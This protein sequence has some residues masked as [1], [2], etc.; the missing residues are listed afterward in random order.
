MLNVSSAI[1]HDCAEDKGLVYQFQS[2]RAQTRFDWIE[3]E[4]FN[5]TSC[6]LH[7][8]S[9]KRLQDN[10]LS[11]LFKLSF[12]K[13]GLANVHDP[14]LIGLFLL[15][16]TMFHPNLWK[17]SSTITEHIRL[18]YSTMQITPV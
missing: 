2:V 6:K 18:Q 17:F 16:T 10:C 9:R 11:P 1:Y 4:E 5:S 14:T 3:T 13:Q 12:I 15:S 7:S 8:F